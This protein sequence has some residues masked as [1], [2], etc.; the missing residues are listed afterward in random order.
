VVAAGLLMLGSSFESMS[1]SVG[2]A[3]GYLVD[4]SKS[5]ERQAVMQ[6][7]GEFRVVVA[8]LLWAKMLDHY[9]H[10]YIAH[11]GE[12]DKN[13]SILPILNTIIELDPHFTQAYML[14]GGTILP[15]LGRYNEGQRVLAKGIKANP[16]DWELN[17]EMAMLYAWHEKRPADAL[18]YAKTGLALANDDFSRNLMSKLCKT[19]QRQI[20]ASPTST[21]PHG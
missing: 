20:A 13:K 3:N 18:P 21:T 5:G 12:W 9:H 19:L 15:K 16:N 10:E 7:A 17:R 2:I 14:M 4:T 6:A 8:N 11:G 1:Q